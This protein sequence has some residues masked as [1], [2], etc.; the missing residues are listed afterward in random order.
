MSKLIP[1]IL[2]MTLAVGSKLKIMLPTGHAR[3]HQVDSRWSW[4]V[5]FAAVITEG[6]F[7]SFTNSFAVVLPVF[8]QEYNE[9]RQRVGTSLIHSS[10]MMFVT[11]SFK[12]RRAMATGF[13]A[14]GPSL[15]I[16]GTGPMT[17]YVTS[18]LG[19][20]VMYRILSAS[21]VILL[22]LVAFS[23]NN[24][25]V[26]NK[27]EGTGSD[28]TV[29]KKCLTS[30]DR[31]EGVTGEEFELTN[32]VAETIS[33]AHGNCPQTT[34]DRSVG[35]SDSAWCARCIRVDCSFWAVPSYT[36]VIL[37]ITLE[38]FG[39]YTPYFHLVKH[40]E[41]VGLTSKSATSLFIHIGISS[42]VG[43]SVSGP[44]NDALHKTPMMLHQL[45]SLLISGCML[46][47]WLA[48]DYVTF[49]VF[50]VLY[51]FGNGVGLTTM[52]LL[53]LNTVK[54]CHRALAFGIGE[55]LHSIGCMLG[56]GFVGLVAD[57]ANSYIPAFYMSGGIVLFAALIP[58]PLCFRKKVQTNEEI[59][60]KLEQVLIDYNQPHGNTKETVL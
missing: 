24:A 22:F 14:A 10:N 13:V 28:V 26:H 29:A 34:A 16:Q 50:A 54:P 2:V 46:L 37:C 52:F 8:M 19:W 55:F 4:L 59:A 9:T 33:L 36:I 7:L 31:S 58:I 25:S 32:E 47:I 27:H 51:G 56:P 18:E 49:S 11:A 60:P 39:A 5:C 42:L 48:H 23:Y 20:R 45:S 40:C 21:S 3:R 30:A 43:R 41:E 35:V 57:K 6:F 17:E 44:L 12:R 1:P 15:F 38:G 53:L